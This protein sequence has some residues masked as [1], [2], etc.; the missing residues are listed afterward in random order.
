MRGFRIVCDETNN[1]DADIQAGI[2]NFHIYPPPARISINLT[3]TK[4]GIQQA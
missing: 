4:D 3:I 2:L 1:T